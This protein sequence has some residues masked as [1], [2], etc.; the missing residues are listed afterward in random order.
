MHTLE[1]RVG[2][3]RLVKNN[4]CRYDTDMLI[5]FDPDKDAINRDK[6]GISLGDAASIDWDTAVTWPD[7][8]FD[9]GEDRMSGL[10]YLGDRLYSVI[11]VDRGN[12]RRIISLRRANKREFEDYVRNL[13]KR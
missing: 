4:K 10:G 6:H 1:V 5:E 3:R 8:R 9:Y 2:R 13:E 11:F 7:V 12:F